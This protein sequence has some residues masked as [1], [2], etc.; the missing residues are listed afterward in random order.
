L[1]VIYIDFAKAFAS[2][3]NR[4]LI[5]ELISYGIGVLSW[6][7]YFNYKTMISFLLTLVGHLTLTIVAKFLLACGSALGCPKADG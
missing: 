7:Q 4:K 3:V 6:I 5:F 1:D 2:V